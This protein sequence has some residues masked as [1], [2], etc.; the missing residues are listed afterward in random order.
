M[1]D[2]WFTVNVAVFA[3]GWALGWLLLWQTRPLPPV[4]AERGHELPNVAIVIPARNEALSLPHLLGPL[5]PQLRP[6]DELVV[7]D[8]HSDDSTAA[9]ATATGATVLSA[10]ALPEGWLG[11]PYA[12]WN[13]ALTTSAPVLLFLDADVRPSPD[14]V[15]RIR[16]AVND[17]PDTVV[18]VQP[19]HETG[20]PGEQVSV[21][22]NITSLMGSGAFTI[23]G[24][25]DRTVAYGPVLAVDRQTY[26]D[27]GG[28]ANETVRS[29]HTEDIALARAVG[30]ASL[31]TGHSDIRFRMYPGGLADTLRGWTRS[32][33]TGARYASWWAALATLAW[34]WSLAGGWIA[35]PWV[36][37]LSA[38]QFWVLGRRAASVHPLTALLFPLAVVVFTLIMMQSA[39]TLVLGRSIDWKG[40]TVRSR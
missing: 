10:P 25:R 12:C 35:S 34:M 6:G 36:Y 40:R 1:S 4:S 38:V 20:G 30:R 22:F 37:P 16:A 15:D 7:V 3:V 14:L 26:D 28:H 9:V 29:M 8:D 27:V 18:S 33:A 19:W 39:V 5:V 11:K 32:I 17:M 2:G 21:L 13:G 24:A 23:A 31:F